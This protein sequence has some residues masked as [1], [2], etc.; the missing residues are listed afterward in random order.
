MLRAGLR[1]ALL[2]GALVLAPP[3]GAQQPGSTPP[4]SDLAAP[5]PPGLAD[6]A[7][8]SRTI[9][10]NGEPASGPDAPVLTVDQDRLFAE[11]SWGLRAQ[12]ELEERGTRIAEENERLATQLSDEEARLTSQRTVLDPAEFRKLAEAFDSRATAVRRERAQAVQDLNAAADAD[13]A[14]FY[15]AALPVMGELMQQRGAVAVLDRRTVFVSLDAIDITSDLI[16]RL[17]ETIGDGSEAR[18]AVDGRAEPGPAAAGDAAGA[19]P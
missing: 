8:P 19:A 2:V 10:G 15:Q 17:D 1:S 14:A 9:E 16:R 7:M 13:R 5:A 4:L 18:P 11:S 3:A 6:D 12:R